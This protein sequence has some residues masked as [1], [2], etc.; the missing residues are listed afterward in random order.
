MMPPDFDYSA[1]GSNADWT[2]APADHPCTSVNYD[3]DDETAGTFRAARAP[4]RCSECKAVLAPRLLSPAETAKYTNG[5]C[6]RNGDVLS[7]ILGRISYCCIDK[8]DV[9]PSGSNPPPLACCALALPCPVQSSCSD[10]G[11]AAPR[12]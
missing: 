11:C 8:P 6:T 9:G 7:L 12:R 4:R 5:F 3:A 10:V 2:F 1:S